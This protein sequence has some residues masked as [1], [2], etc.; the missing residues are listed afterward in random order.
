MEVIEMMAET[1]E[2]EPRVWVGCLA[3]YNGGDLVGAW[4]PASEGPEYVPEEHVRACF[5]CG[6]VGA[7]PEVLCP[8]RFDRGDGRREHYVGIRGPDGLP[9]E[10]QWVMDHEG[11]GG[12]LAG[13]CSPS[14]AAR[15]AEAINGIQADGLPVGAVAAWLANTGEKLEEWDAWTSEAFSEAYCGE[16]GSEADYAEE[17]AEEIVEGARFDGWPFSCID[18][19]RAWRELELG[20][21]N[22]SVEIPSGGVWIFRSA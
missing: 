17:L 22:W 6:E 14:V 20:G 11:F 16:H 13:E 2:L 4:L 18:W 15:L 8:A 12:L 3:C 10:E 1:E 19:E 5:S 21:D 9:H 7:S